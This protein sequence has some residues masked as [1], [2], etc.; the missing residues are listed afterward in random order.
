M[1]R[2]QIIRSKKKNQLTTS[3]FDKQLIQESHLAV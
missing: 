1:D 2:L 3:H